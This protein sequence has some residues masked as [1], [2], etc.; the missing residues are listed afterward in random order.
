MKIGL[1]FCSNYRNPD[2]SSSKPYYIKDAIES[3]S[4]ENS[5]LEN[6]L[7]GTFRKSTFPP[8]PNFLENLS[9]TTLNV[10][11]LNDS[12]DSTGRRK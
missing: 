5:M 1:I 9:K 11:S 2:D 3:I 8:R 4:G 12:R 10:N 7:C 6:F